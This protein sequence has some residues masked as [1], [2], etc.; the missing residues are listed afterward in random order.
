MKHKLDTIL[1][2]KLKRFPSLE[3]FVHELFNERK[4][5]AN[6]GTRSLVTS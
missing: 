4:T 3:T 5:L 1:E 6:R 2:V